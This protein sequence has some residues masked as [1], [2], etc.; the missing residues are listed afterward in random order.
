MSD[1]SSMLEDSVTRLFR[2]KV[3]REFLQEQEKTGW[4]AQLWELTEELGLS[5]VLVKEDNG[6]VGGDWA[7]AYEIVKG[8]G[9]FAVPL[10][11]PE[12]IVARW[13]L[14]QT[15]LVERLLF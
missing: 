2:D 8:C 15:N 6:G 12:T 11:L 9:R 14:D 7:D 13:L 1:I 10:P 5:S 4:A 3:D